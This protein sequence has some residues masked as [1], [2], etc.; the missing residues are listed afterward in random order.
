MEIMSPSLRYERI[1]QLLGRLIEVV[2]EELGIEIASAGSTTFKRT[3]LERG[4][5]PDQCYYIAHEAAIRRRDEID[6]AI[7]PPPDLAIE[8]D[9]SHGP[10]QKIHVYAALGVPEVWRWRDETL[11]IH[12]L[13]PN[14]TYARV[15]ASP[16]FP[17][18]DLQAVRHAL[19]RLGVDAE[20]RIAR[21]F[22]RALR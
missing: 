10:S 2:S 9:L 17:G 12:S 1:K 14:G 20:S 15:D 19:S 21:D 5:E 8:I 22:R 7:D 11:E 6:L 13:G 16:G 4:I 3:D 18:L